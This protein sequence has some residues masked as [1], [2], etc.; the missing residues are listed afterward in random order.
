MKEA[1]MTRRFYN[2]VFVICSLLASFAALPARAGGLFVTGHDPDFHAFQGGNTTGAQHIIQQSL[3]FVTNNHVGSILLVTDLVNPG[4]GYSDPRLGMT[5]AGFTFDVADNGAAGGAV[6][7]LSTVNFSDYS[8]VV[9]ASD[10]GGWLRQSE[11]DILNARSTDLINYLNSGG[12]VVAFAES[13][14]PFGLTTHGEFGYLP[15]LVSSAAKNQNE[16]GNTVTSFGAS[17]GLSDSDI[18]GNA[19]HNVFTATGGMHVVDNDSSGD[20]LSLAYYGQFGP[21]GVV[22]EPSTMSMGLVSFASVM[23]VARLRRKI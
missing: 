11:L 23:I 8:A 21:G 15:F 6:K 4:G 7:N 5:A 9:I 17:L 3:D 16:I 10:F 1:S 20:I 18:N 19:S 22:P 12:G 13:G 14:P 2:L